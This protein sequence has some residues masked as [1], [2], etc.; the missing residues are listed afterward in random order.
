MK[1]TNLLYATLVTLLASCGGATG[2]N[3]TEIE[4]KVNAKVL[5]TTEQLKT[6]CDARVIGAAQMKAD[7]IMASKNAKVAVTNTVVAVPVSKTPATPK[8]AVTT[9]KT[10]VKT[11]V[12]PIVKTP[13]KAPVKVVKT[14]ADIKKDKMNGN[15]SANQANATKDKKDKMSGKKT[16]DQVQV[17]KDKKDK[18]EGKVIEDVKEATE[19]KKNKMMGK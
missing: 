18:M 5:S 2:P 12:K 11:P 10:P 7:S 15:V 6:D 19:K 8:T 16:A 1:K 13:V 3:P 9:V 17:T 14:P 4:A